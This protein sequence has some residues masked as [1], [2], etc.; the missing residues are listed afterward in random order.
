MP[1]KIEVLDELLGHQRVIPVLVVDDAATAVALARALVAGGLPMIEITLRTPAA[2]EA[3]RAIAGEVEEARVGAGTILT[4]RQFGEA[5]E[6]GS[7]FI[8]SPGLTRDLTAVA[9]D[10]PVPLLPGAITP[11]EVMTARDEGYGFLK[12][13]PASAAGGVPFLKSMSSPLAGM[14]FCP[15]GGIGPDDAGDYLALPNV[16]CVG[17]SWVAPKDKLAK[18]DWAGIEALAREA[19]TL[20]A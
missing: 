7:R 13:F 18:G 1:Q 12:F 9:S 17:G 15:T 2:L 5:T 19:S 10:S 8:V 4:A 14:R 3:I 20:G 16:A 6:A 11:S